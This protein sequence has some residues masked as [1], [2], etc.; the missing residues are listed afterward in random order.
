MRDLHSRITRHDS[1]FYDVAGAVARGHVASKAGEKTAVLVK[2]A[3]LQVADSQTMA[4]SA[5]LCF[6]RTLLVISEVGPHLDTVLLPAR[7]LPES[8]SP[9]HSL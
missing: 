2:D 3:L 1:T 6:E 5:A 8:N 9:E 7:R 4:L